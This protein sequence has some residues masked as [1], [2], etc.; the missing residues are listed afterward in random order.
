MPDESVE[1]EARRGLV[2][3]DATGFDSCF[4]VVFAADG[5]ASQTAQH[6][7][8]SD[9]G[10]RIRYGS[11]K[12]VLRAA[13]EG[14]L[15]SEAGIERLQGEEE[16]FGTLVPGERRGVAPLHRAVCFR[17]GPIEQVSDMGENLP[18]GARRIGYAKFRKASRSAAKRLPS[19][20]G[21]RSDSVAK[22]GAAGW[23]HRRFLPS[24][25]LGHATFGRQGWPPGAGILAQAPGSS[26]TC[27]RL[28]ITLQSLSYFPSRAQRAAP[29]RGRCFSACADSSQQPVP[30]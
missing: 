19:A 10:Q 1:F 17:Q 2:G 25:F 5:R 11:L 7:E 29:R 22:E 6:G 20:I 12:K 24:R 21:Q 18:R 26:G 14:L 3:T 8:L 27:A 28:R 13:A 30:R 4:R 23:L 16:T 9:V 15:R